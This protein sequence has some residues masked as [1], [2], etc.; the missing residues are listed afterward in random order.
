M[1]RPGWEDPRL[2]GR[3]WARVRRRVLLDNEQANGGACTLA[4][5]EVCTGRATTVHHTLGIRVTG[6][7]P[8]YLQ[9][10]CVECNL[11]VGDPL[12]QANP[13][14]RPVSTWL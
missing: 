2:R 13:P 5:P 12:A 7:D 14:P 9:A 6:H 10:T 11:H 8:R 3:G 4:L 1:T